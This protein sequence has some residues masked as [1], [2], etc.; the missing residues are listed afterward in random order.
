MGKAPL[1]MYAVLEGSPSALA[2]DYGFDPLSLGANKEALP[3]YREAELMNGRWA[4]MAVPGILLVEAAGG[5]NFWEAGAK[6]THYLTHSCSTPCPGGSAL[7]VEHPDH[8]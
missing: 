1:D 5:P 2:G 3:W 4:M 7:S 6:V 8:L